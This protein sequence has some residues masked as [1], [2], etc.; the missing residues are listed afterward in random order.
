MSQ[1][2]YFSNMT[3]DRDLEEED[4][5]TQAPYKKQ[6]RDLISGQSQNGIVTLTAG[7]C[8]SGL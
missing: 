2:Q 8:E 7:D 3:Y 4:E 6:L 1:N 5:I